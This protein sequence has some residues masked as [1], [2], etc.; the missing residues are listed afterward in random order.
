MLII[1]SC[2]PP[3]G[4][5]SCC[6]CT[7]VVAYAEARAQCWLCGQCLLEQVS[8]WRRWP[9]PVGG[10]SSVCCFLGKSVTLCLGYCLAFI[11]HRACLLVLCTCTR[12]ALLAVGM[13]GSACHCSLMQ[14][15]SGLLGRKVRS[16]TLNT[17][18]PLW[19][20]EGSG[21]TSYALPFRER[22]RCPSP[23]VY[24]HH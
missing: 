17:N 21:L 6:C 18:W 2:A 15:G 23:G 16:C 4:Q 12:G 19:V 10:V 9:Q 7:D 13:P 22:V 14:L 24:L 11:A 5:P 3:G 1:V 8:C 20:W